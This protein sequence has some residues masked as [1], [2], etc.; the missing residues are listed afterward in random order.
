MYESQVYADF[1]HLVLQI[2]DKLSQDDIMKIAYLERLPPYM[3]KNEPP[4]RLLM[5]LENRDR[6]SASRPDDLAK[7]LKMID[8][9]DL[10]EKVNDF[11]AK[12]P[13]A[14]QEQGFCRERSLLVYSPSY[15]RQLTPH[16]RKAF[17][18]TV[19]DL[20]PDTGQLI[21]GWFTRQ[22]VTCTG[23]SKW[24]GALK[25]KSLYNRKTYESA[26]RMRGALRI[27]VV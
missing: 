16:S 25:R 3:V 26:K 24:D 20:P 17:I 21:G 10:A 4:H 11:G 23:K 7:I 5:E 19:D 14:Q 2:A 12:L 13:L 8:R 9:R 1:R 15:R 18:P 27:I 6:V 22:A